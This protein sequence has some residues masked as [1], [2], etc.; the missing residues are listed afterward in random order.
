MLSTGAE[1]NS[2]KLL[3]AERFTAHPNYNSA[4]QENDI[5][6][7]RVNADIVFS[8][9][10]GP[11][12]LPFPYS[13]TYVG[14]VVKVLGK[15]FNFLTPNSTLHSTACLQNIYFLTRHGSSNVTGSLSVYLQ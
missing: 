10:V 7:I 5:A 6:V 9:Q 3:T 14:T 12:C 2:A 4:T 13:T 8:L 1:T 11:A 15:D